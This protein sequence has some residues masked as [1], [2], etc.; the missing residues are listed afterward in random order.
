MN[1]SVLK[2][3]YFEILKIRLTEKYISDKYHE[4]IMRC[5]VHLS[6]GQE[7]PAVGICLNLNKSDQISSNHRCHAHYLAK[8]GSIYKMFCELMGLKNGP[9]GGRGGSMHLFDDRNG[10]LTSVPIVGSSI[11]VGA[12]AG[13]YFKYKTI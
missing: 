5:P 1:K 13:L 10:V 2:K 11:P 9:S 7:G 3:I 4:Q 12:G 8:G 6:I